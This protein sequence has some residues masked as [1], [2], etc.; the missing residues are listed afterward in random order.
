MKLKM[1]FLLVLA[2]A[3]CCVAWAVQSQE[4]KDQQVQP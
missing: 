2:A 1:L 3:I 4:S